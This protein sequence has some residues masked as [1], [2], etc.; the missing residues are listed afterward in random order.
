MRLIMIAAC[1]VA[2]MLPAAAARAAPAAAVEPAPV[3]PRWGDSIATNFKAMAR[4]ADL[5][6]PAATSAGSGHL[7]AAAIARLRDGKVTDLLREGSTG[8]PATGGGPQ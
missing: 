3:L 8:G 5:L 1:G 6:A 7:D 2:A 4:P